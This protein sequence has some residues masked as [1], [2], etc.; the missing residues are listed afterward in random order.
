MGFFSI[1]KNEFNLGRLQAEIQSKL[2]NLQKQID[3]YPTVLIM[4]GWSQDQEDRFFMNLLTKA[5]LLI[6][7]K[8]VINKQPEVLELMNEKVTLAF[9]N[10]VVAEAR[11]HKASLGP[12]PI[13]KYMEEMST[14]HLKKIVQLYQSLSN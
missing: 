10:K 5:H 4:E 8:I 9:I 14:F 1:I 7:H 6:S 11:E 12:L 13:E 3:F 2:E